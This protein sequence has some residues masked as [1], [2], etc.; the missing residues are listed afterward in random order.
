M[1]NKIP[2]CTTNGRNENI[3][4]KEGPDIKKKVMWFCRVL[5][6]VLLIGLGLVQP[7]LTRAGGA[8]DI[9]RLQTLQHYDYTDQLVVKY[10]DPAMVRAEALSTAKVNALS[11]SAGVRLT[12]FRV[13]SGYL[14]VFKF[15]YRMTLAEAAAVA[16][17]LNADPSV[18]YAEPDQRMF[19]MLIPNDPRYINQWHYKSPNAP[20][21]ELGGA[22]LPGAWDITTG[23]GDIVV[24]V[25][26]TGIRP[27]HADITGRT[28]PGYD[29]IS[30]DFWNGGYHPYTA[31]DGDGRDGD[32]SD[33]GDWITAA[34]NAGTD[35]TGGFFAGCSQSNSSWHGTH[36]AGTIGAATNNNIGVA[37]INWVSKILPVRVLGECGG[38]MSDVADGMSWAAGLSVPG[39][40]ANANPAKVLNLSL[41]GSGAC[42]TTMQTAVNNVNAANAVVVAAAGNSNIDASN[43]SPANCNG[44][45]SVAAVNRAGGRAYYSN[46]GTI[47]KIAAPGGA[48]SFAGDSN[49]VLSTL[50][51]GTTTPVASPGGDIYQY[52]QGTSMATPHVTGIASLML[53]RNRTLTPNQVLSGIQTAARAFPTGTGSDCTTST[54]GAGIINAAAAVAAVT[55]AAAAP[56]ADA[57]II[58]AASPNLAT[59]GNNLA[60]TI[61]VA[62]VGP[63]NDMATGVTMTDTL[64]G[65][66]TYV[67]ATPSQGTCNGTST[68]TCNLGSIIKGA[69]A[70]VAVIVIPGGIGNVSNTASIV[71]A[72]SDPVAGNNSVTVN[73]AVNNPVPAISSLSPP[74]AT[75]GGVAFTLTVNG[76]SFV[77]N[78]TVQWSG[79]ARSTTFVSFTQLTAS[80][81]ASD[82]ATAGTAIVAVV[83]TAPGGGTSSG[84]TF[85]ISTGGGGGGGGA[86]GG[87]GGCFIA[88]VAYGSYLDPHVS[89]LRNFRDRYLLTNAAGMALVELYCKNSPPIAD[90]IGRHETLCTL[91]RWILTPVV[92]MIEYPAGLFLLAVCIVIQSLKR[93]RAGK[94]VPAGGELHNKSKIINL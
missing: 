2:L 61:T 75:P 57:E 21:N 18:E 67:S 4:S 83:N 84:A 58:M 1:W 35:S 26:D 39:A 52:Y 24:A 22:N 62:N 17:R 11:A 14:H 59:V 16:Q 93:K 94:H 9:V 78:S 46:F 77:S 30:L 28:V 45:I 34:E 92:F 32:P 82:I 25:I 31:N 74:G 19:P 10:R 49:G 76:S 42:S 69:N 13:M 3:K 87:G 47:V 54:C 60:Y 66:V 64:P 56:G 70:T 71:T 7:S 89:V 91:T 12:H 81:L 41:G 27:D 65:N 36:V 51:S 38:Y 72:S 68:V 23:S 6:V 43:F 55:P 48:M 5:G 8:R 63:S 15:A 79:L 90:F 33:P 53:S 50:N 44:V 73:T 86:S 29:F 80:I 40:P 85:T 37:G 20:D 88:T